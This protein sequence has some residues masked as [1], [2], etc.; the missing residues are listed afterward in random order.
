MK[1]NIS[2]LEDTEEEMPRKRDEHGESQLEG[3]QKISASC[4]FRKN[5]HFTTG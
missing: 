1:K 5:I 2:N 4:F 3:P